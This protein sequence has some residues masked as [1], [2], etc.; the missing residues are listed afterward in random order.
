MQDSKIE[1]V[2]C[3]LFICS[4][5][6]LHLDLNSGAGRASGAGLRLVEH[7]DAQLL[8][9]GHGSKGLIQFHL[10]IHHVWAVNA[11]TQHHGRE[12]GSWSL[13]LEIP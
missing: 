6:H 13:H 11:D 2:P 8:R 9:H 3:V 12:V 10:Y 7:W 4:H 5:W 1:C